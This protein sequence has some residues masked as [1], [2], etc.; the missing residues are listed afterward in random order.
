MP[1]DGE[2]VTKRATNKHRR[3]A[4]QQAF[5]AMLEEALAGPGIKEVMEIHDNA[6]RQYRQYEVY[7]SFMRIPK[8]YTASDRTDAE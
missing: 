7:R 4:R 2:I 6:Q 3:S 1:H 8:R 5:D